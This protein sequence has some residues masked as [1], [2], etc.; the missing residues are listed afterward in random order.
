MKLIWRRGRK[1]KIL[2]LSNSL[3]F[4]RAPVVRVDNLGSVLL[5]WWRDGGKCAYQPKI[6]RIGAVVRAVY[7]E[8]ETGISH[9]IVK[10]TETCRVSI[11]RCPNK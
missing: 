1:S 3:T 9:D 5:A 4:A 6:L 8:F 2:S 7:K 10:G 11:T